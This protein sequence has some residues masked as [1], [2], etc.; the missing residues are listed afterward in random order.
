M[1]NPVLAIQVTMTSDYNESLIIELKGS[2]A[3]GVTP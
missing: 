3:Q 2:S 1:S